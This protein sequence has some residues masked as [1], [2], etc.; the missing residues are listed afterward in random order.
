[1][2][3]AQEVE[4]LQKRVD[5]LT[6]QLNAVHRIANELGRQTDV[7][8]IV[9]R[10]LEVALDTLGAQAGSVL[11]YD[12]EQDKLVFRYVVGG[13]GEQLIGVAIE[14]DHGIAGR[15]FRDGRTHVSENVQ[16]DAD[17]RA[18]IEERTK[19]ITTNM[20]TCPLID[21]GGEVIG[22]MQVLN[23]EAGDFDEDDVAMLEVLAHQIAVRIETARLQ[24]EAR[25]AEVVKFIGNISHDVK[26]MLTP[27]QTGVMTLREALTADAELLKQI[28]D[29]PDI[30]EDAKNNLEAVADDLDSLVPEILAM[31]LEGAIDAQNRVAEISNA[32]K[33]FVTKP[34]FKPTDV[35]D[36]ASRVISVLNLQAESADVNLSVEAEG[37]IPEAEVDGR[38]LYNAL[39]NLVFNA[40]EACEGGGSVTVRLRAQPDGQFPDG[41]YLEVAVADTGVGIPE[42]VKQKLFTDQ[43]VSTKPTGTGLGTRIVANAV[44]A[45]GGTIHVDSAP[46]EGTT[47]TLRLPLRR[48]ADKE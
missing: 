46:G 30:P 12:P 31:M 11:L 39:Y 14:P 3:D 10:A 43:A 27:V 37:D 32:V 5:E 38:Q 40:I 18:D 28:L 29:R 48:R 35:L 13:A 16:A 25:L 8:G 47:I 33:G 41:N 6:R 45:H 2:C 9:R 4:Q 19:Y 34:E 22:V 24:E 23:K 44:E 20:V 42:E 15:V 36:I 7:D 17:H 26:N 1:M 21:S